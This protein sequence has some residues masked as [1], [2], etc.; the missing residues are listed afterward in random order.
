MALSLVMASCGPAEE[1]EEEQQQEEEEEEEEEE[2]VVSSNDP[3]YGG[4]HTFLLANDIMG[5]DTALSLQMEC[6]AAYQVNNELMHGAWGKGPAGTDE[7]DWKS[8]FIG[9]VELMEGALAESWELPDGE[10]IIFNIRKGVHW[11]DKEPANGREYTAEDAVWSLERSFLNPSSYLYG[12]YPEHLGMRP[13]SFTAT[14]KYT[15][16]IKVNAPAQGL[17]LLVTGDNTMAQTCKDVVEKY[18]DAR[19]WKN[20]VGTGPFIMVDYVPGSSVTYEKNPD[21]WQYDPVHPANRLPYVDTLKSLIIIDV[22]TRQAALRTG[23]LDLLGPGG[24]SISWEDAAMFLKA[25]SD[26]KSSQAYESPYLPVGRM[27]KEDLPFKDIRVRQALNLAI[28][29]EEMVDDYYDGNAALLGYPYPPTTTHSKIYT[30]LD[31]QPSEPTIE[32]SQCSVS[33][34]IPTRRKSFWPMPAILTVS[35]LLS[36]ARWGRRLTLCPSFGNTFSRSAS[37]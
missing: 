18:G 8:G 34:I 19:D 4:T 1:E 13:K 9:R 16:E 27:D 17:M 12:A 2:E 23:K 29:N 6:K 32:G 5:F 7:T 15:V 22:S 36:T 37:I 3:I 35:R 11:Q 21:Y 25:N 28:N 20:Q 10:T 30:P 31:E 14:D 33:H 24:A 26:L